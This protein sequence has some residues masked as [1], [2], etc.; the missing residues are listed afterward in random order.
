ME[1]KRTNSSRSGMMSGRSAPPRLATTP[2]TRTSTSTRASTPGR[3]ITPRSQRNAA[4]TTP[5]A[6]KP[7]R[8]TGTQS[9]T[10]GA[11]PGLP[12]PEGFK[13]MGT[14]V[15]LSSAN[16]NSN[17]SIGNTTGGGASSQLPVRHLLG[18]TGGNGRV[19]VYARVRASAPN[20]TAEDQRQLAVRMK[21]NTVD[22]LVP[23][24][25]CFTFTFDGAF[26]SN[27]NASE[28]PFSD[29]EDVFEVIGKPLVE[30][31]LA[32][33]NAAIMA[34]GQTGSGKTYT[35]FGPV[36]SL[37][38]AEEGLIPRVCEMIFA[39]AAASSQKG[40][41]YRLCAS[42]LEVYLED[43]FDLLNHRKMV[44]V[45]NDYRDNSFH[46]VG[47]KS[48]P[49]RSYE[50]VA[51]LLRKAEP[52]RTFAATAIHDRSSRAH[53]LFQ[54]EV[55]TSFESTD[56]V[57]RASKILLADLAGSERIKIAQTETGIPFEQA[58]NINLSLLALGSCIEAVATRKGYNQNIP[59]FRNSTLTKLL[60]EYLGGNSVSAMVVTIA[61]SARDAHLS[62]QTLRFADR[63]KQMATHAKINTVTPLDATDD[64]KENIDGELGDMYLKKKEALYAEYKLQHTIDQLLKKIAILEA[65]LMEATNED[66]IARLQEEIEG[67]QKSLT[68]AD[69]QLQEQ[70][71]LLYPNEVVLEEQLKELNTRM[72]EMKEEHEEAMESL[73]TEDL[74]KYSEKMRANESNYSERIASMM[75]AHSNEVSHLQKLLEEA[76][77]KIEKLT[78][79][80]AET[81]N[82]LRIA[83]EHLEEMQTAF[84][85]LEEMSTATELNLNNKIN[86][87]QLEL[88]DR[89]EKLEE[90]NTV[91][92][93]LEER[94]ASDAHAAEG[95]QAEMQDQIEQLEVDVAERDQ[96]L[97]EMMAAQKELEERYASD[98]H[99]AE[100]KQA[101][102]QGQIE[103]LEGQIEQ[104]EVDVA[105]RDQKLEEMMA[106]QKELE[107]RYASDAHAAEGKQAEM[108]DQIEQLEVD[109]AERDQKLEE[110]MAA[111]KELEERYAGDAHAAEGKQA[112]MQGQIEQ[113]QADLSELQAAYENAEI[114]HEGA[115]CVLNNFVEGRDHELEEMMAAQKELEVRHESDL[116]AAEERQSEMQ[117]RIEQLKCDL[118][119]GERRLEEMMTAQKELEER[120]SSDLRAAERK[121]TELQSQL[122]ELEYELQATEKQLQG[123]IVAY[124]A[125]LDDWRGKLDAEQRQSE[126]QSVLLGNR[127][128][129]LN[130]ELGEAN[131]RIE[132]LRRY[133]M[134]VER[135]TRGAYEATLEG[136]GTK[137]REGL[138]ELSLRM[139]AS[140]AEYA[141]T[142][143]A[144]LQLVTT[145]ED[146]QRILEETK[147]QANK[148]IAE[149]HKLLRE[150]RS[151]GRSRLEAVM[152]LVQSAQGALAQAVEADEA[153]GDGTPRSGSAER[154][155][156]VSIALG[157]C[158]NKEND[159]KRGSSRPMVTHN[160]NNV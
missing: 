83:D 22:V 106:A 144:R 111:Q 23:Q 147:R 62:V 137:Q 113:L 39:R 1:F 98:A 132:D 121:Q 58:R 105:E 9:S 10:R 68:E 4:G 84:K 102:M 48:V 16:N 32:G 117:D 72:Q 120:Y 139:S 56:I 70:R 135:Y 99:A 45:R 50:E 29:Q 51:A 3:I 86:Q 142:T 66:L 14:G 34:Y 125:E 95:K 108:Q 21:D 36:S 136:L 138:E 15:S 77:A 12:R 71:R 28:K 103:Q 152:A 133:L 64:G 114:E 76:N 5:T 80:L 41:T 81:N 115:I 2:L 85:E 96:K 59:E 35:A 131:G 37:G 78:A 149:L 112:E 42:M 46:V 52:L 8:P 44:A 24:K 134:G 90:L 124:E 27:E 158:S 127:I 60:K 150:S 93:D 33:Y 87:L 69:T 154:S 109:V 107:E 7:P 13:R 146:L 122:E 31:A 43:V 57:P 25:G 130:D 38:T 151:A 160:N 19:N 116:R 54:L 148:E 75:D 79:S 101:E 110:M 74:R 17:S 89:E 100:G 73:M 63:A 18:K 156:G 65:Q 145:V 119:E 126:E 82:E 26:W 6:Q 67:L 123:E 20:E 94:Y 118:A 55:Q 141:E 128:K 30:N 47:A 92:K 153:Y 140:M 157:D 11:P 159:V 53:T 129:K 104:L 97:E 143:A 61:P 91:L 155:R 49:V 88:A 40:V